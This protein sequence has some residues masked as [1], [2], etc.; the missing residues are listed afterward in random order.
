MVRSIALLASTV[1]GSKCRSD[2]RRNNPLPSV[3][4]RITWLG[5]GILMVRVGT[6]TLHT[7]IR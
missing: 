3:C 2:S 7:G 6:L 1:N 4:V 5:F